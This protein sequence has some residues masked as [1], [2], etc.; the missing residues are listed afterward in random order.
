MY[1][2]SLSR[3]TSLDYIIWFLVILDV[4]SYPRQTCLH[5]LPTNF[6]YAIVQTMFEIKFYISISKYLEAVNMSQEFEK[7]V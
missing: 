5:I 1:G 4:Y 7:F 2:N 3:Q 6:T